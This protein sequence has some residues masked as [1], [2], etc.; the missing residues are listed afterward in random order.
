MEVMTD[1]TKLSD[2]VIASFGDGRSLI[3]EDVERILRAQAEA[4]MPELI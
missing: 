4:S 1:T 3:R 2:M